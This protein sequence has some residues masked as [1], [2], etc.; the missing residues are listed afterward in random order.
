MLGV[1]PDTARFP[2]LY[3]RP[4]CSASADWKLM[5]AT[6]K[7]GAYA[8]VYVYQGSMWGQRIYNEEFPSIIYNT[9]QYGLVNCTAE[10]AALPLLLHLSHHC[11]L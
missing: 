8:G 6:D 10:V 4:L 2:R 7:Q 5:A 9:S 1:L 11:F 3:C